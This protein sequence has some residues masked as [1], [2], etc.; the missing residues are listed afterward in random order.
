MVGAFYEN[1]EFLFDTSQHAVN[2][3]LIAPDPVTGFTFDYKKIHTTKTDAFSTFGSLTW[4]PNDQI[5]VSG[6][7]RYTDEQKIQTIAIPF[8]HAL[9]PAAA[10]LRSGFFSGPIRFNDDNIS[11]EATIKYR[12]TPD[13]NVFASY[14]TGFKSG[15]IDNSALPSNSLG[16]AART[17]DFSSLIYKSEKAR[18]GEVG[19]KS[20]LASNTV[21]LN[22]TVYYYTFKDLQ[23]QVFNATAV[24]FLTLNAGKATTKGAELELGWRTPLEGLNLSANLAYL[25]AKYN[26]FILPG[27]DVV[28]GSADDVDLSGRALSRAPKFAGNIAADWKVPVGETMALG[29]GGNVTFS[30]SYITNSARRTDYVQKSWATFDARVSFGDIDDR[31]RIAVVGVNLTDKIYTTS[32]GDRP[33]LAPPNAFG[34]PVGDDINLNNNRGRQ[35]FVEAS[36]KF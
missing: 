24:Q 8:V 26:R 14:K 17:G 30:D 10:F 16:N 3:S 35:L 29:L 20:E 2:I 11:P 21:T 33:F 12:I 25:K 34:V 19:F 6:G 23:V 27:P 32:S 18:G 28:L 13:F 36:V 31:W 22:G 5:E 7:V 15:G 1:R 4:T 9:L